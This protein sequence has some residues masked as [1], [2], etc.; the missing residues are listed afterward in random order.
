M[1]KHC[2]EYQMG[3]VSIPTVYSSPDFTL[4][5]MVYEALYLYTLNDNLSLFG[6]L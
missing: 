6:V 3:V 5:A 1:F 2:D 4:D